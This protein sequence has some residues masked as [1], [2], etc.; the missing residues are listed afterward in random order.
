[1]RIPTSTYRIQF[2]KTF[3]FSDA[4][5]MLNYLHQ[6][7]ITDLY[8]SP[9]LKA[10]PGSVHGYDVTDPTQLN[11]DIGT[12]LE[13]ETL[14][15]SLRERKMGLVLDI[16]PN[17]MA[18]S[19]D[20]PWWFD[21]LKRGESSPFASFFD[22]NW[23]TKKVLLPIL[24]KPYGEVLENN[25]L[26]LRLEDGRAFIQYFDQ[27]LPLAAGAESVSGVPL[28]RLLSMQNYRLAYWRKA[29][30]SINYRRFFDVSDLVS[31]SAEKEEVYQATH[32]LVLKLIAEGK[33]TGLR[34]DHID[35]LLDPE[36]YLERLPE[37][38]VVVEKILAGTEQLP[39]NWRTSGTTGYDFL[40]FV[41][42]AF[43]DRSGLEALNRTYAEFAGSTETYT[44]T[45]RVRKRQVMRDLFA[46]EVTALVGWLA[47]LAQEDRHARDLTITELR[48]AFVNVTA[49]LP[50]YRTYIRE[51]EISEEDRSRIEDALTAASNS[52]EM[53]AY[54]FLRRVLLLEPAWYL[55]DRRADYLDFVRRWQ[56][57]TGPIMAKGL[58][59][60]TFYVRNALISV[61]EVGGD[62]SGPGVYLGVEEFHRRNIL[63]QR[64]WPHTMNASS[65]HDT[66][67]SED[68]R[69]RINIL[70]E[71]PKEWTRHLK[72]WS[73]M[74]KAAGAPT[75]NEEVLIYQSLLG[76]WPIEAERLKQFVT[77]ALREGKTNSSW[78]DV[79]QHYETR[80]LAFIDRMLSSDRFLRSFLGF[81]KK[82][83]YFGALSS[84]SQLL[85][86]IASPG[87]PD[88]YQ[89]SDLWDLSLADPDNRRHVDFAGR[90][91]MLNDLECG[92]A[93]PVDLLK[94][95]PDG[96]IKMYI[97][98]KALQFR[99][100]KASLFA[101]GD[102]IPLRITGAR[103]DHLIAFAR[104][105]DDQWVIVAVPRLLAKMG[106]A[107]WKD[108]KIEYPGGAPQKW[109]NVL[110]GTSPDLAAFPYLLLAEE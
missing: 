77:K 42:G 16:V 11:P 45:F 32:S 96:R 83:A 21:V 37:T 46:G 86:K 34:V 22:V 64:H 103:E 88:F 27:I 39:E 63:R 33:V 76:A 98:W 43:V 81:Q 90:A 99:R 10:R 102:Y 110:T 20:N 72:E 67:R 69:T 59:D 6:L 79:N 66:K 57:F 61:N 84:L 108:T 75:P 53:P 31:L 4:L 73:R 106:K 101:E 47:E 19:V 44:E 49:C 28:D 7:G 18:A 87:V 29:A 60:T 15:D 85:L 68:V 23:D 94:N 55:Q 52:R 82:V 9:I 91:K 13:F 109:V 36:E 51:F 17:H 8:S 78:M 74:N 14:S 12:L 95:W 26:Q 41:N 30:D 54:S 25:E 58:E 56:Q 97:T 1:M 107:S 35:G 2:N 65:T 48:V 71:L 100:E 89:G 40:N 24:A 38:Y 93:N 104:R 70:S 105:K 5:Q 62:S 80:V 92:L 50:V 3:G